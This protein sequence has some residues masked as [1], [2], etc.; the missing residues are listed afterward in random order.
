MKQD[1]IL[2]EFNLH[3]T[4]APHLR[5]GQTVSVW[6]KIGTAW[7]VPIWIFPSMSCSA[8]PSTSLTRQ[9]WRLAA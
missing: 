9:S 1:S 7:A 6:A 4:E 8:L 3:Q 5:K 2:K